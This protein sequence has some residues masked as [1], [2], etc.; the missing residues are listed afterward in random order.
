[1]H[2]SMFAEPHSGSSVLQ[3]DKTVSRLHYLVHPA[4]SLPK[5]LLFRAKRAGSSSH[6]RKSVPLRCRCVRA[7]VPC[8]EHLQLERRSTAQRQVS[9]PMQNVPTVGIKYPQR[10]SSGWVPPSIC[11]SAM[12]TARRNL[13]WGN[14]PPPCERAA[15]VPSLEACPRHACC[16]QALPREPCIQYLLPRKASHSQLP[17]RLFPPQRVPWRTGAEDKRVVMSMAGRDRTKCVT[18]SRLFSV[19]M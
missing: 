1:M 9:N 10:Q 18:H 7:Q 15:A 14:R 3:Q 16:L 11:Q 19:V 12:A 13:C 8:S 4:V 5:G 17:P 2:Q 6:T